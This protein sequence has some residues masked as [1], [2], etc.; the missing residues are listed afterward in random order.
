MWTLS[1]WTDYKRAGSLFCSKIREDPGA[2]NVYTP[3][4]PEGS[5]IAT[6]AGKRRWSSL[7]ASVS[8]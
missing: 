5:W 8:W 3:S 1:E 4:G 7:S 6:R 2:N